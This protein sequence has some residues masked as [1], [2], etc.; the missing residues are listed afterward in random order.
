[1]SIPGY[2]IAI[3]GG[4]VAG[5]EAAARLAERGIPSVVFEQNSLPY[6]KLET[7]LPKWH[8]N[9]RN[10]Q[11]EKIDSKLDQPL[12]HFIPSVRLGKDL[13]ITDLIQ[14]WNFSAIMLATGAWKDRLLP[15]RGIEAYV[16]KGF[17]YQ[18]PFVAWFNQNHDPAYDGPSFEVPDETIVIGGGLASLDV[19]KILSIESIRR[20]L[21]HKGYEIDPFTLEKDG[22]F[23]VLKKFGL[24][25]AQ[26]GLHGCTLYYR[27]RLIDMPLTSLPVSPTPK[28]LDTAYRVRKKIMDN[29]QSKYFFRFEECHSPVDFISSNGRLGGLVFERTQVVE[30]KLV[31]VPDSRHAVNAPQVISAIGSLPEPLSGIPCRGDVFQI[32]DEASGQL[33]GFENVFAL[34]NAVT[35]RG[36]IKESQMHG[37]R[38]S[39]KVMDEYLAWQEEDYREIFNRA[40]KNAHARIDQIHTYLKKRDFLDPEQIEDIKHRIKI[41]Q[42]KVGYH[43]NYRAWI[44]KHLP[45]RLEDIMGL[46]V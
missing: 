15:V 8:V 1:M 11:E 17:Y 34:G 7:G 29:F 19:I 13:H 6:G 42:E 27:R 12:I 39:E 23:E 40:E 30:G 24:S 41:L 3:I 43:G 2:F 31:P 37:R 20:A 26:L 16:D 28:E 33:E 22:V 35:G 44:K 10:S 36:N 4:A 5:S 45:P 14:E 18:N 25:I 9:L 21:E 46:D 32:K 38:V